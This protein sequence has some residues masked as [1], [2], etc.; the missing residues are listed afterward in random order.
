MIAK[1]GRVLRRGS[2]VDYRKFGLGIANMS[3]TDDLHQPHPLVAETIARNGVG[4]DVDSRLHRLL[5]VLLEALES[6]GGQVG[7][8]GNCDFILRAER[9]DVGFRFECGSARCEVPLTPLRRRLRTATGRASAGEWK[10]TGRLALSISSSLP[11]GLRRKWRDA[12]RAPLEKSLRRM[13]KHCS[14]LQRMAPSGG[15]DCNHT[16]RTRRKRNGYSA[17]RRTAIRVNSVKDWKPIFVLPNVP[18]VA[19]IGCGIA[20]LSPAH[21]SSV[22]ALKRAHPTLG[23]FPNRFSDNFGQKFQ[24]AV[25]LMPADA[26][27]SS[28]EVTTRVSFRDNRHLGRSY[29]RALELVSRRGRR[30]TF[31]EAFAILS[32]DAR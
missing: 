29:K 6:Y 20:A 3:V 1:V 17:N 31:G 26:P 30:V 7:G 19:A 13:L 12:P 25:M 14:S 15:E 32:L 2:K 23:R 22:I 24:P 4:D 18:L 11:L 9:G 5:D 27:S 10:K 21:D 28:F 8:L 16:L